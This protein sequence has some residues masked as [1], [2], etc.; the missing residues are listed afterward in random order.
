MTPE[1]ESRQEIDRQLVQTGWI[2]QDY[3]DMDISAGPGV[4]VREFPLATGTADYLLYVY[5]K[6]LGGVEAKPR[7]HTLV[8]VEEQSGKYAIG[9]AE[10]MPHY[11]LPLPFTYESTGTV[12][13]VTNRLD[14]K[15]RAAIID[16]KRSLEQVIDETTKDQLVRAGYDPKALEKAK[17]LI[18]TFKQFIEDNKDEIEAIQVLYSRPYRAGL[19]YRHVKEL[20]AALQ[21]PPLSAS[22]IRL[23]QAY[24]AVEPQAVKAAG[25]KQ[26]VDVI[27]LVRH[28]IDPNQPLCPIGMTV[29]ERFQQW[30][31]DQQAAGATFTKEQMQ[32]LVA[33][34]DH[35]ASSLS[36]DHDDFEY[37]PFSQFGGLGKAYELFGDKLPQMLEELNARLAA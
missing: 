27:A 10:E 17:S 34:R 3:R 16:I 23:W 33:I 14:P 12:T 13:Q 6:A 9:V 31:E 36:I 11:V 5:A 8:G 24:Q 26:L 29:R 22:P 21:K 25:G 32:W 15:L 4:A 1:Q 37:A 28:A 2:V 18:T 30:I 35:V 19:R 7:G 20:A